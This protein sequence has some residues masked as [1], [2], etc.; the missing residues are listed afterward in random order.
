MLAAIL[1]CGCATAGQV[2][3][4]LENAVSKIDSLTVEDLKAADAIAL[5]QTPSDA[6]AHQCFVG[7][8]AYLQTKQQPAYSSAAIAGVFSAFEAA[9]I[10]IANAA[11]IISKAQLQSFEIACAP[12]MIDTQNQSAAFLTAVGALGVK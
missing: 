4:S 8:I 5:A 7:L 10:G 12:L 1:L 3:P 9:R 6:I 2:S 11:G